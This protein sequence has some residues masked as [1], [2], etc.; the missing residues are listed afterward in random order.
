MISRLSP[1]SIVTVMMGLWYACT[2][3]A[4]YIAGVL[5]SVLQKYLPFIQLF[6]F[7]TL[8][9]ICGGIL[10]LALSPVL[11]KMTKEC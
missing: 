2:A 9:T 10:L 4:L 3:I 1:P 8:S 6:D 5:E 7:L 11:I